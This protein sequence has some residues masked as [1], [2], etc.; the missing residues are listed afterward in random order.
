M[1]KDQRIRKVGP[2]FSAQWTSCGGGGAVECV[3]W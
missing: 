1:G 3:V 2:D